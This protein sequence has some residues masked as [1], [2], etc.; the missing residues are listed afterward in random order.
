MRRT[1]GRPVPYRQLTLA[2]AGAALLALAAAGTT[3]IDRMID[4]LDRV[5]DAGP[6][7]WLAFAGVYLVAT[8]CAAPASFLQGAAGFLLGPLWGFA[9]ASAASVACSAVNFLLARTVLRRAV[10]G[11]MARD[12]SFRAVDAAIGDGGAYLVGLLRLSPLS[13][14]NVISY[15][16]GLTR[17]SLPSYLLGTWVGSVPAVLLYSYIGSTVRELGDLLDGRSLSSAGPQAVILGCTA[18]ATVLV[19]RFARRA[20]S[21]ALRGAAEPT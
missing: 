18:A 11:W 7:G 15:A 16:L 20:L 14:F 9:A 19:A 12:P 4:L 5:R 13:P 10:T 6:A 3:Q 1:M 2:L 17:V 8:V 21:E